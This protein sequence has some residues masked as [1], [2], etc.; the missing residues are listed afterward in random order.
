MNSLK[1]PRHPSDDAFLC[2]LFLDA[3]LVRAG[4]LAFLQFLGQGLQR[5]LASFLGALLVAAFPLPK[6][7][8][9]ACIP[10][11]LSSSPHSLELLARLVSALYR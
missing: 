7:V 4:R 8:S 3:D 11:S 5:G 6:L 9:C 2:A 10:P 1:V